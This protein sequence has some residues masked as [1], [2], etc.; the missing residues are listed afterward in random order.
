MSS[1]V[2]LE[3]EESE[4]QHDAILTMISK[5]GQRLKR[6]SDVIKRMYPN[7]ESN[8]PEA[9]EMDIVKLWAGGAVTS[10]T[11]NSARK[12]RRL[13]LSL[14][15]NIA[16]QLGKEKVLV[17]EVDCCHHLRNVWLGGMTK[18]YQCI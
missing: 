3:G 18:L 13:L 2:I 16:L 14:I 10:D 1:A 9:D 12:N 7:Y 8:I 17:N 6:R 4:Q 15:Q 11:C 5:G